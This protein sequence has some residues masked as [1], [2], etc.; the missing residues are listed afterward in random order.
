MGGG[1]PSNF[2]IPRSE[3]CLALSADVAGVSTGTLYGL[4]R[5]LQAAP[6][7]TLDPR[8]PY[9]QHPKMQSQGVSKCAIWG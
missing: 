2:L 6:D 9:G 3:R 5:C 7:V 1:P 8:S 4:C